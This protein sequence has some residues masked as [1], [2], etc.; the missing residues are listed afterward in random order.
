MFTSV[1]FLV[2][3]LNMNQKE[4]HKEIIS[5]L[6]KEGSSYAAPIKS[7]LIGQKLRISPSYVRTQMFSLVKAKLVAVRRGNG[8]GY[9]FIGGNKMETINPS[10]VYNRE[11]FLDSIL[12]MIQYSE[13]LTTGLQKIAIQ[14]QTGQESGAFEKLPDAADGMSLMLELMQSCIATMNLNPKQIEQ[15][16]A[17]I[18]SL[19]NQIRAMNTAIESKDYVTLADQCEYELVEIVE[20]QV[21]PILDL[22]Y[23]LAQNNHIA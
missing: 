12:Y 8:G 20:E 21:K 2:G 9:Y 16:M 15:C 3:W 13:R 18:H 22:F 19:G 1:N 5:L 4:L 7:E 14:L 23:R 17:T 10:L 6:R 11:I